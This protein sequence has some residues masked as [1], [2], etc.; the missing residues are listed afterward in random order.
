MIKVSKFEAIGIGVS[1]VAMVLALFLMRMETSLFSQGETAERSQQASVVVAD[2]V[3]RDAARANAIVEASA[4][5]GKVDR[6]II[7]DVVLG[8]GDAAEEGDTI[9]VHYI[10]TLESG[11]QF[12]NSHT[13]GEP[14]VF[15][16]GAG[17]VIEG[18]EEGV[19]GMKE[20]GQRILVVPPELGYGKSG[21]GPIPGNATLVFA[22]ELIE[23]E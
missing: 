4:E 15:T 9:S 8:T 21:Y 10:G 18:W 5:T 13:K 1:V 7:D 23:I 22:I 14:F 11:Q 2:D 19:V 17:K 20:G 6:L 3:T 12:D 16:V